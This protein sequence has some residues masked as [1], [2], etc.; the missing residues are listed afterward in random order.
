MVAVSA[1]PMLFERRARRPAPLLRERGRTANR[2]GYVMDVDIAVALAII[3][4]I[5][6]VAH[7]LDKL[8]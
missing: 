5:Q 1:D 3:V 2:M 4:I 8:R 7:W 6:V